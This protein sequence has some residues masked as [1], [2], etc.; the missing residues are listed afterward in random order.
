MNSRRSSRSLSS[1]RDSVV[2]AV[3]TGRIGVGEERSAVNVSH[4][5]TKLE[6]ARS[7][8]DTPA[9]TSSILGLN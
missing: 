3:A 6:H 5:I 4:G 8:L 1:E 2:T 9:R 7:N